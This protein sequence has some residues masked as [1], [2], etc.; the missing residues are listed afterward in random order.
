MMTPKVGDILEWDI[1]PNCREYEEY[2]V[3]SVNPPIVRRLRSGVEFNLSQHH[4][5]PWDLLLHSG[6]VRI[7]R[8]PFV[9]FVEDVLNA[10]K[11]KK[12]KKSKRTKRIA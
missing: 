7:R 8:D 11:S 3:V 5:Y 12:G 9:V 4:S 2:V 10:S 6:T 1:L